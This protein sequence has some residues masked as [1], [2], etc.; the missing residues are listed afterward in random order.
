M[1]SAALQAATFT[2]RKRSRSRRFVLALTTH[3]AAVGQIVVGL[4]TVAT[5]VAASWVQSEIDGQAW[6]ALTS[7]VVGAIP[8]AGDGPTMSDGSVTWQR[9]FGNLL[10]MPNTP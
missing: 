3:A 8:L 6:V 9:W 1:P 5:A 4:D 2:A 7:G 10:S